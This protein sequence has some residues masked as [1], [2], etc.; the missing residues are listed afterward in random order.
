[1]HWSAHRPNSADAATPARTLAPSCPPKH[2]GG[3]GSSSS[4]SRSSSEAYLTPGAA[5]PGPQSL[6]WLSGGHEPFAAASSGRIGPGG[7]SRRSKALERNRIA[8]FMSRAKTKESERNL[9]LTMR[10]LESRHY[11]LKEEHSRLLQ[12]SL[13][14]KT[15]IIYHAGCHDHRVDAW[16]ASEAQSFAQRLTCDEQR[17]QID[18]ETLLMMEL[19]DSPSHFGPLSTTSTIHHA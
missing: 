13:Q 19:G 7:R 9:E 16:I 5:A 15:D 1:M 4:S 17:A 8:S 14:L 10:Q 3:S 18:E 11:E 2:K 6:L 12:Q